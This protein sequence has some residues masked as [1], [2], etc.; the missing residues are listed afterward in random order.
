MG[1]K[2][3]TLDLSTRQ[4][5]LSMPNLIL[6]KKKSINCTG[7]HNGFADLQMGAGHP[8]T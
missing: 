7:E 6:L 4:I 3:Q 8:S 1:N 5:Q 2:S